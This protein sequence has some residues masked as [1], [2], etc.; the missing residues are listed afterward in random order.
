MNPVLIS[1]WNGVPALDC[2]AAMLA[3]QAD[4]LDALVAGI[5][6]V[7]DDPEELS[8]GYG[9]LPNEDGEVELDAIVM[10]GPLHRSAAVAG[11]R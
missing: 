6:L 1:S 11:V 3:T 8:V 5:Q 2:T 4:P 10:H 9:G 7:E